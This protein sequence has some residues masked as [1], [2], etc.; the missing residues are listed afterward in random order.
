MMGVR[1]RAFSG[2]FIEENA[3]RSRSPCLHLQ[4]KWSNRQ[5]SRTNFPED[6][7]LQRLGFEDRALQI[8]RTNWGPMVTMGSRTMWEQFKQ[9]GGTSCHAWSA[10]PTYVL[11]RWVPGA[12][13]AS[14]GCASY[15]VAPQPGNLTW[16]Q[17]VIP[18]P[19]GNVMVNWRVLTGP[20]ANS[21]RFELEFKT[22]FP[23]DVQL[24]VP[25]REG[26]QPTVISWNG[27]RQQGTGHIHV[28]TSSDS[29]D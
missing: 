28:S 12:T 23:A 8:I 11:S 10:S 1:K 26:R 6:S 5:C 18:T 13:P 16:A 25:K 2:V 19:G 24:A 27:Q 4:G 15:T 7:V 29:G 3:H 22:P 14:G 21:S 9:I 20:G 17:G